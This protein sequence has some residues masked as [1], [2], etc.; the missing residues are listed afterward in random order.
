MSYE[1]SFKDKTD[2]E[3]LAMTLDHLGLRIYKVMV[4]YLRRE[5][6]TLEQFHFACTFVGVQGY[7]VDVIYKRY[8]LE[9]EKS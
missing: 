7:P 9:T 1:V 3:T 2:R 8:S 4:H 6:P 5:K